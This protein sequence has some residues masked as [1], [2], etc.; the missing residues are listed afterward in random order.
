MV[1][2]VRAGQSQVA[3]ELHAFVEDEAMPGLGLDSGAFWRG[4]DALLHELAPIKR[5]LLSRR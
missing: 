5:N 1:E 3:A 2:R 4:L